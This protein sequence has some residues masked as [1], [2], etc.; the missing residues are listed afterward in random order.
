M[1]GP[2]AS[3]SLGALVLSQVLSPPFRAETGMYGRQIPVYA[4]VTPIVPPYLP[5]R[6]LSFFPSFPPWRQASA[7]VFWASLSFAQGVEPWAGTPSART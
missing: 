6:A 1:D 2:P 4:A 7:A 3:L 5:Y